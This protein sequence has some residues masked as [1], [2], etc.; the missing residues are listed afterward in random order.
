MSQIQYPND[1]TG[2]IQITHGS[3]GRL[4]VSAR[5]DERIFYNSRDVEQTYIWTSFD[6]AAAVTEYS[7]Y[8]Q[9]TS[10]TLNL[11]IKEILFSPGVAMTFKVSTVT[12]TAGGS[13]ITGYNFNRNSGN[14]A[15]ANA[16]GNAAVTGLTEDTVILATHV[17]ALASTHIDFHDALILGQNDNIAIECD[18]NAGGLVYLQIIGYF[19]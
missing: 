19:E 14:A 18:V 13:A 16:F 1:V 8:L 5:S 10:T 4:N 11:I 3:D 12:G 7:I 2:S 17:S 15:S 6:D 9:N